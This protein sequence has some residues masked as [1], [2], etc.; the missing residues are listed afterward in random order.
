[1][2]KL[3]DLRGGSH[4]EYRFSTRDGCGFLT[5]SHTWLLRAATGLVVA[6][7]AAYVLLIRNLFALFLLAPFLSVFIAVF[8][9]QHWELDRTRNRTRRRLSL[10]GWRFNSH[11]FALA[12]G[13]KFVVRP[14]RLLGVLPPDAGITELVLAET[15]AHRGFALLCSPNTAEQSE[16]ATKLNTYLST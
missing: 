15:G 14:R 7:M 4:V 3:A 2:A 9:D 5:I 10:F 1:M 8:V 16:L 11:D 12:P 13:E 6:M